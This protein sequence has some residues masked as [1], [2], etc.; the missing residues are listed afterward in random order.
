M[1]IKAP[2][3]LLIGGILLASGASLAALPQS[4]P[5]SGAASAEGATKAAPKAAPRDAA[6]ATAPAAPLP[7]SYSSGGRRD[8]FRDLLGGQDAKEKRV[9]TGFTDLLLEEIKIMGVVTG[10]TGRIAIV[11]LPEGFPV[12]VREGDR[13]AEGFVLSITDGQVVLRKT[14]DRGV[15]L[16]KPR[17]IVKEFTPE[18]PQDE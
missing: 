11:A 15:P 4:A 14:R 2:A 10:K 16:Q 17:D 7:F 8:P 13:F 18:E 6:K 9:I 5:Q 3:V 12:Q 1:N